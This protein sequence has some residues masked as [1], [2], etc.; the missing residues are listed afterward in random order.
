MII[1]WGFLGVVLLL[2]ATT[3]LFAN[4]KTAPVYYEAIVGLV[5]LIWKIAFAT[6]CIYMMT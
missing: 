5:D 1:F 3:T 2:I 4:D 6:Y